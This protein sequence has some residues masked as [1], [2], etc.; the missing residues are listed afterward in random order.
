MTQLINGKKGGG[1]LAKFIKNKN[2]I[3]ISFI[4]NDQIYERIK[5]DN[6]YFLTI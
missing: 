2:C 4:P 1:G 5:L 6:Y 3:T